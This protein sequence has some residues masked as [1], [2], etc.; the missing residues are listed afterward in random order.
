MKNLVGLENYCTSWE[1]E[2]AV[3]RFVDHYNVRCCR[4]ALG[5]V[6]PAGWAASAM[7]QPRSNIRSTKRTR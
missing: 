7:A 6:T 1:P 5:N 4:E 2:R 3:A